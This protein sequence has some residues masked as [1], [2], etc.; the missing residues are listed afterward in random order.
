[1]CT[2][3]ISDTW[4]LINRNVIFLST[5]LFCLPFGFVFISMR[6][7]ESWNLW[8][9]C[10]KKQSINKWRNWKLVLF[11]YADKDKDIEDFSDRYKV[12]GPVI[13][14]MVRS[15]D[16]Y[17]YIYF[18]I[19]IIIINDLQV[20]R[21]IHASMKRSYLQFPSLKKD[22]FKEQPTSW[23]SPNTPF[24]FLVVFFFILVIDFSLTKILS[25]LVKSSVILMNWLL[26]L[27]SFEEIATNAQYT[28]TCNKNA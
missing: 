23:I 8:I 1:M 17:I 26:T 20:G 9:L 13:L 21:H 12:F 15:P 3:L 27:I 25:C 16:N 28:G 7:W 4:W 11:C 14:I 10:I 6:S 19:I 18:I 22:L 2:A 24:V 5:L